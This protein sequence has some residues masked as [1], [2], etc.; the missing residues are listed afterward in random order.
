VGGGR[1]LRTRL[2]DESCASG[3]PPALASYRPGLVGVRLA[4][5]GRLTGARWGRA[6]SVGDVQFG[7]FGLPLRARSLGLAS[8]ELG[9]PPTVRASWRAASER[10]EKWAE[11]EAGRRPG[12][13]LQCV[14]VGR[15]RDIQAEGR[16]E[17]VAGA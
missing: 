6:T 12:R 11:L 9:R 2:A 7:L 16:R 4:A 3:Q 1:D 10:E 17:S 5:G 14:A 13:V 8:S 15:A